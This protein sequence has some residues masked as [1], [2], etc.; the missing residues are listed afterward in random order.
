MSLRFVTL[1]QLSEGGSV[2]RFCFPYEQNVCDFLLASALRNRNWAQ[3]KKL[4]RQLP[5]KGQKPER[6]RSQGRGVRHERS[7]ATAG[8]DP[9]RQSEPRLPA[10]KPTAL[11]YTALSMAEALSR[12][13]P[14]AD[15]RLILVIRHRQVSNGHKQ[16]HQGR[17]SC[18]CEK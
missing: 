7:A 6:G 18:A 11:L 2:P 8:F 16:C 14:N 15:C 12:L 9:W 3:P 1:V 10:S 4:E 5:V 13:I 17:D